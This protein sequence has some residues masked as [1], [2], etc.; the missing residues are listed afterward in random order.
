ME[1]PKPQVEETEK[2]PVRCNKAIILAG[3][4]KRKNREKLCYLSTEA[5]GSRYKWKSMLD[6]GYYMPN[7]HIAASG[8]KI[9]CKKLNYLNLRE[10]Y[11]RMK[12]IIESKRDR[13]YKELEKKF[14]KGNINN[15]I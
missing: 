5:Y 12:K 11:K 3:F 4:L 15:V 6:K 13:K 10:V 14:D 8:A 1:E 7:T 2:E 9:P